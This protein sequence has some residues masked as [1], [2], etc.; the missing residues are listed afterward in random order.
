MAYSN[1]AGAWC[2]KED[3]DKEIADYSEAIRLDPS[4]AHAYEGRGC[5]WSEK[6]EFG[7][8]ISDFNE[9]I[10]LDPQLASAFCGRGYARTMREE[11]DKAMA[12]FDEAIR[13]DPRS[14]STYVD[15]GYAWFVRKDDD[16]A[17]A[18]F[19]QAIR[20]DPR[21]AGV[22]ANRG[23]VWGRKGQYDKAIADFDE[24]IRLDP[25]CALAY[26]Y[27]GN[28]WNQKQA[29]DRALA[30]LSEALLL[31]PKLADAYAIRGETW[32]NK[33]EFDRAITDLDEA[34][35]LNPRFA[36]AFHKRGSVRA[37]K[38]E[39]E[40]AMADFDEAIRLDSR[41]AMVYRNRGLIWANFVQYESALADYSEAIRLDPQDQKAYI[42]R[43]LLWATCP[44]AR[45]RDGK[46]AVESAT[47]A[48]E[49]SDWKVADSSRCAGRGLRRGR[50]FRLRREMADPGER[51]VSR[52]RGQNSGRRAASTSTERRSPI[53]SRI[54]DVVIPP[55]IDSTEDRLA[56]ASTHAH[57]YDGHATPDRA[58]VGQSP[59]KAESHAAFRVR[60]VRGVLPFLPDLRVG[61]RRRARASDRR[62][63]PTSSGPPRHAEVD[64]PD[65][66]S[67]LPRDLLLPRR[68]RPLHDLFGPAGR[69][70][71]LRRGRR[72]VPG[73]PLPRRAPSPR[74]G[75]TR[76]ASRR[77]RGVIEAEHATLQDPLF[78]VRQADHRRRGRGRSAGVRRL[79][80][81]QPGRAKPCHRHRG[82]E[83]RGNKRSSASICPPNHC[84][85]TRSPSPRPS[86]TANETDTSS[87]WVINMS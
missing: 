44:D 78:I 62:R 26:V 21:D 64:V 76:R 2:R 28:A 33:G 29:S 12:D 83:I 38:G 72:P 53:A 43:A 85:R 68:V 74:T 34:I 41:C 57:E 5:G 87:H 81:C 55:K 22:Y 4:F 9:A 47:R 75:R 20:L 27:R 61:E 56:I 50:R 31:K 49:L 48:C 59:G 58:W 3:H 6:K 1:R 39:F 42:V 65:L 25:R 46:K 79:V 17:I 60:R 40:K 80:S 73:R 70:P 10:R 54:A 84:P 30:D 66:P 13:L 14:A 82:P 45:F 24:A 32:Y 7:K 77:S 51:A 71:G 16:R 19:D 37:E 52:P 63:R 18:D 35:R 69:L 11:I 15:R 23:S 36:D 67:A 86:A 8:A